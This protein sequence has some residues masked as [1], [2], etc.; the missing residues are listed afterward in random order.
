MRERFGKRAYR[1]AIGLHSC[2]KPAFLLVA[3][4][5]FLRLKQLLAHA[6]HLLSKCGDGSKH[7][8]VLN[9]TQDVLTIVYRLGIVQWR[10]EERRQIVFF[11]PSDHSG[12]YLAEA[13]IR[14]TRRR[15]AHAC[16]G[17]GGLSIEEDA[18]ESQSR[19]HL[20]PPP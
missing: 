5:E 10:V 8:C 15:R 12:D 2:Q 3:M 17:V 18:L 20:M 4:V 9:I 11:A 6:P 7:L 14:K 1:V 13:Q 16:V 19:T